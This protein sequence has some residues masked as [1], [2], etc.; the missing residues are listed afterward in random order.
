MAGKPNDL[1][2]VRPEAGAE[3]Q[4]KRFSQLVSARNQ[5]ASYALRLTTV[6]LACYSALPGGWYREAPAAIVEVR[7]SINETKKRGSYA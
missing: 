6:G 3:G 4:K 7:R 1:T 2:D 5:T